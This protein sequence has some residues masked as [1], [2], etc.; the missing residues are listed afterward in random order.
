M[1]YQSVRGTRDLL[2]ADT[3][4]W[5][6][7]EKSAHEVFQAFGYA[8]VRTPIFEHT[9]LF[10]RGA[11]QDSDLVVKKE[12]Y[13]F[14]DRKGR[15][16]TLRPE[17]TAPV[18]RS[19]LEHNLGEGEEGRA[20]L[21]YLGPMFRYE[22]P[23]AGRYR[24]FYTAGA[25]A[26]GFGHPSA[27]A[28]SIAML[29]AFLAKAGLPGL[30]AEVNTVGCPKC[31]PGYNR[32][33]AEFLKDKKGGLSADSQARLDTNPLRILDSKLE[34]DLQ[35]TRQAPRTIDAA[36]PECRAHFEGVLGFLRDLEVPFHLNDRLVRG[37][38]YYTRTTFEVLSSSLGSQNAVAGGGRYDNMVGDF[39]GKESRPA[40]GFGAGLDRVLMLLDQAE[41]KPALR[42]RAEVALA[43]LGEA[44]FR[45]G[46]KLAGR[47]R[48]RGLRVQ[49]D[50]HPGKGLKAQ[51]KQAAACGALYTLVLGED[52]MARGMAGLKDM[53][54]QAQEDVALAKVVDVLVKKTGGA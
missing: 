11:G 9:E 1:E 43:A 13:T 27:D 40:V 46:F 39:S 30:S 2:P 29:V 8:E 41:S 18:V 35:I 44:A 23:Q 42:P 48:A 47:L 31:R 24:Q 33:L 37:L 7:V 51:F 26:I 17:G 49:M 22:R 16:L 15:S 25:E 53:R 52:E 38:D 5:Q 4:R 19:Y 21:Y 12:M 28:E 50:L 6:E 3:A 36:C 20:K 32:L 45:E 10:I 54:T 34:H 14:P